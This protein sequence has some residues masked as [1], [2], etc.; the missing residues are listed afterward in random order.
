MFLWYEQNKNTGIYDRTNKV[1]MAR[2][3]VAV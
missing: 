3:E 1:E 2:R